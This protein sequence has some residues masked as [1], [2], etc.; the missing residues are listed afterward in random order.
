[1]ILAL[2][3]LFCILWMVYGQ[4]DRKTVCAS[5]IAAAT[6]WTLFL[7]CVTELLSLFSLLGRAVLFA[8]WGS[9]DVLLAALL[10]WQC[11][12]KHIHLG[13]DIAAA[14]AEGLDR[15]RKKKIP[16]ILFDLIP[17]IIGAGMLFPACVTVPYN[18]DSMTY[19]LPRIWFWAENRSVAHYATPSLRQLA[20]PVLAEYMGLH[21]YILAG[22]TD[23][24]LNLV[25]TFS[26]LT[27][28]AVVYAISRKIGCRRFFARLSA[29]LYMCIPIL[30]A[31]A[32]STQVD[33]VSM[34]WLLFY[35]YM[36]LDI[37]VQETHL[38]VSRKNVCLC[39]TVGLLVG[40]AYSTK[41]TVC[42]AMV[43]FA[44]YLLLVCLRRGDKMADIVKLAL[45]AAPA[46]LLPIL[47]GKL[48]N[49]ATFTAADV[50]MVGASQL[51]GTL[52]PNYLFI[53]FVKNLFFNMDIKLIWGFRKVLLFLADKLALLLHVDLDS[54]LISEGGVP[55][56]IHAAG[57]YHHDM[58]TS[59]LIVYAAILALV[60]IL[61]RRRLFVNNK[62]AKQYAC[63]TAI[64]FA[65]FC[66]VVRWEGFV[67][68]YMTGYLA[69]LCPIVGITLQKV[70]KKSVRASLAGIL[71]FLNLTEA[72]NMFIY[73]GGYAVT[74]SGP[75]GYIPWAENRQAY[76]QVVDTIQQNGY[77]NIG[78]CGTEV[79]Q[80]YPLLAMLRDT[81]NRMEYVFTDE[82]G[83]AQTYAD[84]LKYA[85]T[86][87][88]PDCVVAF[89]QQSADTITVNGK[90]YDLVSVVENGFEGPI[91]LFAK[92]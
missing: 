20:S 45:C 11:R 46:V 92:E 77:T 39:M 12:R 87:W 10:V 61:C 18:Y 59:P 42:V 50:D 9:F 15:Y 74:C 63:V 8:V 72:V 17:V 64:G 2:L 36:I 62:L 43:I 28:A 23:R 54:K 90:Q 37:A 51:V 76:F 21:V 6:V 19:H 85:D 48:R 29:I 27:G 30:F 84:T 79:S 86:D 91:Y 26:Y 60:F 14:L 13:R 53:S 44:V 57:E 66:T 32:L 47:P 89:Y 22:K 5:Y 55:Y 40:F 24:L 25:Q 7:F 3:L 78:L 4:A 75:G 35:V 80:V 71:V 73:H 16:Q 56:E 69:L 52:A 41:P 67:S 68:R 65:V 70:E 88:Q 33:D 82:A 38:C 1:M 58:A 83:E 31:E 81:A 49:M 34:L